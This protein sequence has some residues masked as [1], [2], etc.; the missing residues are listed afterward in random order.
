M[1]SELKLKILLPYKIFAELQHVSGI[2]AE[3]KEG[4]FGI[5]PNRLDCVAA[6]VPGILSYKGEAGSTNYIAVDEGVLIKTNDEVVV[7]VRN[8][9]KGTSLEELRKSVETEFKNLDEKE[10][11]VRNVLAKLESGFIRTLEKFRR[12]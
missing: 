8:A 5:L 1:S 12:E 2:T 11:D 10:K 6:L 3:T 9:I 4:S 7:S